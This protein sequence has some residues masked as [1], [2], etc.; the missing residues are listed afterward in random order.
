MTDADPQLLTFDEVR[1][2]VRANVRAIG[3]IEQAANRWCISK[4]TLSEILRGRRHPGRA[5]LEALGFERVDMY[6]RVRP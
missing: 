1:A 5:V 6:R 3:T 2:A 4:H